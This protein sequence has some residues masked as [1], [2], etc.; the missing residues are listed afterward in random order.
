MMGNRTMSNRLVAGSVVVAMLTYACTT[1]GVEPDGATE[2]TG[3]TSAPAADELVTFVVAMPD[4]PSQ[5]DPA[6]F[7]GDGSRRLG[8]EV[9]SSMIRF[10]SEQELP[11]AGCDELGSL[12]SIVGELAESWEF[13]EDG[14]ILTIKLR[15]AQSPYGNALTSEDVKWF[16]DRER[17]LGPTLTTFLSY[18]IGKFD[19]NEPIV[20]IDDRTLEIHITQP[21]AFAAPSLAWGTHNILD[22]T[23]VKTHATEEDPWA[24]EWVSKNGAYFGPWQIT[25]DNFTPDQEIIM[26]RNENYWGE[27]GNVDRLIFREVPESSTRVQLLQAGEVDFAWFL[28]FDEY[29]SLESDPNVT[30]QA[31]ASPNR[32][33]LILNHNDPRFADPLVRQAISLG[34][35]RE[36]IAE[37]AYLGLAMAAV[38][39]LNQ[40]HIDFDLP[41]DARYE[42]D[43]DAARQLLADAGYPDGFEMELTYTPARPGPEAEQASILIQSQLA[44]IGIDVTLN[45]EAQ[46]SVFLDE[47]SQGNFQALYVLEGAA[48]PDPAYA[49]RLYN[50]CG[51]FENYHGYCN[52]DFDTLVDNLA[53]FALQ[54]GPERQEAMTELLRLGIQ[55]NPSIY[56]VDRQFLQAWSSKISGISVPADGE[57]NI[58]RVSKNP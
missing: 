28:S 29:V 5:L 24:Q 49:I 11:N 14:T 57:L 30:V 46:D 18:E 2:T 50:T 32:D 48:L 9:G 17:A 10:E 8:Y 54:S 27:R 41:D 34:I 53:G 40:G 23:E 38:A 43:P 33:L 35:N 15:E 3:G 22:S 1:G 45:L 16:F 4:V 55:D 58:Y 12:E 52:P 25:E 19:E 26:T 37:G 51:A 7:E 6:V 44:E 42:Y 13:N 36:E 20:I 47:W 56:I 39:P 31:C 21:N